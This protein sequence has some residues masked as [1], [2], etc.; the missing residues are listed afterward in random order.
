MVGW[1]RARLRVLLMEFAEPGTFGPYP[2]GRQEASPQEAPASLS[3][4]LFEATG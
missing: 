1:A 2:M 3:Q 4:R